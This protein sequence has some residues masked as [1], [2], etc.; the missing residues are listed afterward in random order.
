MSLSFKKLY[1]LIESNQFYN[2]HFFSIDDSCV[3]IK[4][5]SKI[6][7][8][9][10]ML[11]IPPKYDVKMKNFKSYDIKEIHNINQSEFDWLF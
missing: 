5:I 1:K 11:Y 4:I 7:N 9:S 3:F 6:D 2:C 8:N 10:Y